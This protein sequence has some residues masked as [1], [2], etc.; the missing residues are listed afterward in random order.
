MSKSRLEW[1]VGI[2]VFVGLVLMAGLLL[3]F[4]KG[5]TF[6]RPTKLILLRAANVGGLKMRAQ[7]LMAGVQ[8]GTVS[9]IRLG[10][11]GTNV[12]ITLTIFN[13]YVIHKDARFEI[14]MS[15]FLG[16]QYI[17]IMPTKNQGEVFQN[18]DTAEAEA[19]FN[20]QEVARSA[21]SFLLRIEDTATRLND[22]IADVR[23][24]V[25]NEQTLTNLSRTVG[26]FSVVSDHALTT[27]DNV[28]S[29]VQS[30]SPSVAL[31]VSNMVM[32]SQ[33]INQF[34]ISFRSVLTSNTAQIGAVVRNLES[35]TVTLTNLLEDVKSGKGV[36]GNLLQNEAMAT[37]V[38]QIVS[39][40][41]VTSSNLNRLGLW[42]ILWQH[43]P[44]RKAASPLQTQAPA[45]PLS[46][47]K[48]SE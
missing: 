13:Q 11:Q 16:D 9:D 38:S 4:S 25:L 29:L 1:K 14:Q 17:S 19:P 35:S 44:P 2:F 40:L 46:S 23:K 33:E 43:K 20:M 26:N 45:Q 12:T 37:N 3:Q 31:A 7:V 22:A 27:V 24:Q 6:F 15:G 47:P 10:P 30:N 8:V 18:G 48:H 42:G 34:A 5:T 36:A 28:N 32:F 41:S 21:G 39:N